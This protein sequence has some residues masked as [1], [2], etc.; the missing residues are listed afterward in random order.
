MTI[1]RCCSW[2]LTLSCLWSR[3]GGGAGGHRGRCAFR[4]H[5]GCP[6]SAHAHGPP[7]TLHLDAGSCRGAGLAGKH[8]W[9]CSWLHPC[10]RPWP[11][12]QAG[13]DPRDPEGPG[14][15][16][17]NWLRSYYPL[18]GKPRK[19]LGDAINWSIHIVYCNL[20]SC[21]L[22]PF[23]SILACFRFIL[24]CLLFDCFEMPF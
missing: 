17:G 9:W 2:R 20:Y 7:C 13:G 12:V 3:L 5:R 15:R 24:F 23:Y 1:R 19:L 14:R 16:A 21:I 6:W 10:R 18:Q 22:Y 4:C 11:E 8:C